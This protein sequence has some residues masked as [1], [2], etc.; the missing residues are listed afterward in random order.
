MAR[1]R[2]VLERHQARGRSYVAPFHG[3][4]YDLERL[5]RLGAEA[6]RIKDDPALALSVLVTA[7]EASSG[8]TFDWLAHELASKLVRRKL[9]YTLEDAELL[10]RLVEVHRGASWFK[11]SCARAAAAALETRASA[12][13][14]V[15]EL[16]DRLLSEVVKP[17]DSEAAEWTKLALRVRKLTAR[18]ETSLDLSVLRANDP[19]SERV[20]PIL[21]Q[22]FAS[23]GPLLEHLATATQSSRAVAG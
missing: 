11:R 7:L 12:G 18:T 8:E 10:V 23:C 3:N 22:E 19:W 16:T 17:H 9:P 20:R 15:V 6:D 21:A 13:D 4:T 14:G 2:A 1:E 5:D